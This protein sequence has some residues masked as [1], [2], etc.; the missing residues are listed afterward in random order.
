VTRSYKNLL[1][2]YPLIYTTINGQKIKTINNE[3]LIYLDEIALAY[4]AMVDGAW[5]KSGFYLHTKGF[6]FLETY[7]LVAILHY[8]FTLD[9][10]VQDH[11]GKPVIYIKAKSTKLLFSL[12]HSHFHQ[13][14]MYKLI[15]KPRKTLSPLVER[16]F[17]IISLYAGTF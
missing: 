8:R 16:L 17:E 12:V 11:D 6:T 7:R 2:L 15:K 1:I 9:C 13:S 4:W 10:S 14:M 3:L 5:T